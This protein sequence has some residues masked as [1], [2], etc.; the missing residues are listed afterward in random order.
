MNPA[1]STIAPEELGFYIAYDRSERALVKRISSIIQ[2]EFF[3]FL[4]VSDTFVFS[5]FLIICG[6]K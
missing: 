5:N 1:F 4:R 3:F 2:T 6:C